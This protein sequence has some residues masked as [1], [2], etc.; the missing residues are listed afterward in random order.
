MR[1]SPYT[2]RRLT[3]K[4]FLYYLWYLKLPSFWKVNSSVCHLIGFSWFYVLHDCVGLF[5]SLHPGHSRSLPVTSITPL[6]LVTPVTP[7]TPTTSVTPTGTIVGGTRVVRFM[8][9]LKSSLAMCRTRKWYKLLHPSS[10][11]ICPCQLCRYITGGAI[12]RH[13]YVLS[14]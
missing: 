2:F 5:D 13:I 10:V 6:L 3:S 9:L 4:L 11:P 12:C 7:V 8:S 14:I 1:N